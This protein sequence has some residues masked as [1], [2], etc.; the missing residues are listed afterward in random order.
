MPR[1]GTTY[2]TKLLATNPEISASKRTCP[3]P[4]YI[5]NIQEGL[6]GPGTDSVATTIEQTQT[7]FETFVRGGILASCVPNK[8]NILKSRNYIIHTDL[9]VNLFESPKFIYVIRDLK[10]IIFSVYT[11]SVKYN[12]KNPYIGQSNFDKINSII[13]SSYL[14]PMINRIQFQI[15]MIENYKKNFLVIKYEDLCKNTNWTLSTI[16]RF[17]EVKNNY[18]QKIMDIN[19]YHHDTAYGDIVSHEIKSTD[20]VYK[21]YDDEF[22]MLVDKSLRNRFPNFYNYFKY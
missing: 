19:N 3:I 13:G 7:E 1:S 6:A 10:D 12:F 9:L 2:L 11:S 16:S 4:E 22:A 5:I 8:T 20:I 21:T 18:D 15:D 17:L 14:T